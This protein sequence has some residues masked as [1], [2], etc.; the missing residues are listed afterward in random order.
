[1]NLY[2]YSGGHSL[3]AD[4]WSADGQQTSTDVTIN[5]I[6]A[7]PP[8]YVEVA[9]AGNVFQLRNRLINCG[10]TIGDSGSNEIYTGEN[11]GLYGGNYTETRPTSPTSMLGF[12][13]S[14]VAVITSP[15]TLFSI[16]LLILAVGIE[17]VASR[18]GA[19]LHGKGAIII[20]LVGATILSIFGI[21]PRWF[22]VLE[23]VIVF[24]AIGFLVKK[25][26]GD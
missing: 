18:N 3:T 4:I 16:L 5:G 9:Q 17:I 23:A 22:L 24:I 13:G 11:A 10:G 1:L 12:I 26:G 7:I 2:F 14:L 6:Q 19:N 21:Y 8:I 15:I 25:T 20:L